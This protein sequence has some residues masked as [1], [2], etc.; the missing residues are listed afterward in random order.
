MFHSPLVELH[1][2]A[3]RVLALANSLPSGPS[4]AN[5]T[6]IAMDLFAEYERMDEVE[7]HKD[8]AYGKCKA[9]RA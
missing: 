8:C 3:F 9:Q 4:Q 2:L 6:R 7:R 5:L 1:S